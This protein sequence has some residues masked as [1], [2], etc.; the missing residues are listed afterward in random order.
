M[1]HAIAFA[2]PLLHGDRRLL[3]RIALLLALA[4]ALLLA[5]CSRNGAGESGKAAAPG[6]QPG[7]SAGAPPALPVHVVQVEPRSVPIEFEVVGQVEGSKE[8][9]VRARVY[10]TL[11]KQDYREGDPVRAGQLMFEIDP[12]PYEIALAQAKAVLAQSQAK[13]A[14]ARRD[15]TGSSRSPPT[16]RSA[17]RNT[18]TRL[19][20]HRPTRGRCSRRRPTCARRSSTSRT[21]R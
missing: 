13:L 19:R 8:V 21:P 11:Q 9:E 14:Q 6:A 12:A 7:A 15:E 2:S 17:R 5:G 1:P 18:T 3:A 20:P 10:G 4:V 16:A